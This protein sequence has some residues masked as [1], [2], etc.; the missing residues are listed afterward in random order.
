MKVPFIDLAAQLSVVK[1][2][3]R[4]AIDRVLATGQF[5]L[6]SEVEAFEAEIARFCNVKYAVGVSNGSDALL[7]TLLAL[8]VGRGDEVIVPTFTFFGTAGS[9][10]HCGATPV[11]V[12]ML[13]DTFNIDSDAIEAAITPRTKAIIPVHI[14]GQC[15]DMDRI[16]AVAEKRGLA[17]IEDAAQAIGAGYRGKRAGS[18][19]TAGTFSF[20]P[21]KNLSAIG[22]A[23]LVTTNDAALAE[24]LRHIRNHG[25]H[26]VYHH[27]MIG[28]NFRMD[29]IQG[30]ALRVKLPHVEAWNVKRREHAA[31]YDAAFKDSAVTPPVAE[32]HCEHIYHQYTIRSPQ[33]D[34]LREHLQTNEIASAVFYPVPLHLQECFAHLGC[35]EGQCPV[36][37]HAVKEVL[38]LPVFPEMTA[39]QQRFVIDAVVAFG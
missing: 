7:T 36:A 29:G 6:G 37:E 39:E 30:A 31:R 28:G 4:A 38:S 35:R 27:H 12:D 1:D 14:F 32:E 10:W 5:I 20:Y 22:E 21:T 34:A 16:L 13:P 3:L 11:F 19:G 26:P 24:K 2:D 23:G 25:M 9:V 8:G 17:V 33:R 15:A 18:I